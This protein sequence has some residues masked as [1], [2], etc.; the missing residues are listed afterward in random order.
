MLSDFKIIEIILLDNIILTFTH[1]ILLLY[2]KK[3]EIKSN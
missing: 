3:K 2:K 1:K